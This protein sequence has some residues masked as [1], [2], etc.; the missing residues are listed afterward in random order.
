MIIR[1]SKKKENPFAQISKAM[2][3]DNRLTWKAKGLLSYLLSKPDNW[4]VR[5]HDLIERSKDQRD[6]VRAAIKELREFK[7]MTFERVR[8]E[9]GKIIKSAY[10]V[11]EEPI[12]GFPVNGKPN[13]GKT[14]DGKPVSLIISDSSDKE[15]SDKEEGVSSN[16]ESLNASSQETEDLKHKAKEDP[17]EEQKPL[18]LQVAEILE[19]RTLGK[20]HFESLSDPEREQEMN[21][22]RKLCEKIAGRAGNVNPVQNPEIILEG[23]NLFLDTLEEPHMEWWKDNLQT[24]NQLNTNFTKLIKK[25]Q[26]HEA[27]RKQSGKLNAKD[28]ERL[29]KE[30]LAQNAI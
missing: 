2:L 22:I 16:S 12:N 15:L 21:S 13:A 18:F 26:D 4:E 20:G 11:Y 3:E 8:D 6:S 30:L 1:V 27:D 10:E 24:A 19:E 17:S 14:E 25:H 7:Y 5:I 23:L 29:A 9:K 28:R